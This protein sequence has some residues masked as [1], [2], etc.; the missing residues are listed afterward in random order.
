MNMPS[1]V[2][3]QEAAMPVLKHGATKAAGVTLILVGQKC[4]Q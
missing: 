1:L 4:S 2:E 3:R